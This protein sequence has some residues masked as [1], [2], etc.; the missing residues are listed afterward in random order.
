VSMNVWP[1]VGSRMMTRFATGEDLVDGW[2]E[3]Q[4]GLYRY[5]VFQADGLVVRSVIA[6]YL[7][8][9]VRWVD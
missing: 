3:V 9:E 4:T 5:G 2:V 7:A 1:E 6:N 8:T